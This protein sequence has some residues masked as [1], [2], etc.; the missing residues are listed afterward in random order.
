VCRRDVAACWVMGASTALGGHAAGALAAAR[1]QCS[2]W[3]A[4]ARGRPAAS[5]A[6]QLPLIM[7]PLLPCFLPR[8]QQLGCPGARQRDRRRGARAAAAAAADSAAHP[9]A[10][11]TAGAGAAPST[12]P[13]PPTH[14]GG[15]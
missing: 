15:R 6:P 5:A 3:L 13:S 2:S 8:R 1:A 7:L 14:R 9:A 11:P 12:S 4:A 10:P